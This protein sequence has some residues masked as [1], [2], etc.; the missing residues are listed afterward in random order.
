MSQNNITKE[1]ITN[2]IK[3]MIIPDARE[4]SLK[5]FYINIQFIVLC[6][7][8]D[9]IPEL[10]STLWYSFGIS[11]VLLHE[12]TS[13]YPYLSCNTISPR[14]AQRVCCS[15]AL[16]QIMAKDKDA[17]YGIIEGID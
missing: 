1:Q 8:K 17:R 4:F 13:F 10:G 3:K 9:Q 5:C 14:I 2:S 16:L 11:A 6:D 15:I 7:Q 12:I